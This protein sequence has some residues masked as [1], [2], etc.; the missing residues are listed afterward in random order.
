MKE[1][2]TIIFTPLL[3]TPTNATLLPPPLLLPK[4]PTVQ[5]TSPHWSNLTARVRSRVPYYIHN[6]DL[7]FFFF[8]FLFWVKN[9]KI[10]FY[11]ATKGRSK[12]R[13]RRTD[14]HRQLITWA[15][16]P[17]TGPIVFPFTLL[18]FVWAHWKKKQASMMLLERNGPLFG[19]L[20]ESSSF[21]FCYVSVSAR[22]FIHA[23]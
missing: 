5:K 17:I 18:C 9:N 3:D 22:S 20:D 15:M 23:L 21:L 7:Y 14:L 6:S 1:R 2:K 12:P 4:I 11:R 8:A 10:L 13:A 16:G 19:R